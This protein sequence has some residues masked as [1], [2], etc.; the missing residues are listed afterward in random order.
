MGRILI[1]S[2]RYPYPMRSGFDLRI[3]GLHEW[4][5][6]EHEVHYLVAE[7]TSAPTRALDP[8]ASLTSIEF[9]CTGA[10]GRGASALA[11]RLYRRIAKPSFN[12][13]AYSPRLL[14]RRLV[15]L[16]AERQFDAVLI[17]TPM[18][19]VALAAVTGP[20]KIIDAVDLWY[21]RYQS[22]AQAGQ[23]H[24]LHHMRRPQ[25]ELAEYGR[26]AD[27]TLATSLHDE[28]VMRQSGLDATEVMHVPVAFEPTPLDVSCPEP[29]I[30]FAGASGLTNVDAIEYFVGD[31]LPHICEQIPEAKLLLLRADDEV[32][33][34]FG[35]IANVEILPDL[36]DVRDAY[37]RARV[38]VVPLRLG[39]G[40]KIKVLESFAFGMPTIV[41]PVAGQGIELGRYA[42]RN[43]SLEPTV[44]A[45]EVLDAMQSVEYR[46]ELVA[47]ALKTIDETYRPG[48]AYAPLMARL[49]REV[50]AR[51]NRSAAS[52]PYSS[53]SGVAV[54]SRG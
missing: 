47:S 40:I 3:A 2:P 25:V 51:A 26:L 28:R 6:R 34:R 27:L 50:A 12:S 14:E 10:E 53:A 31:V 24:L 46:D 37:R 54:S 49:E 16:H 36:E 32:R 41:S 30:L 42:Q 22:F 35:G 1:V 48:I 15:E 45:R 13:W 33:Q 20:F 17:Q 11:R 52:A 5:A 21:E 9:V 18:L 23:G 39:S 38:V 44:M 19:A 43:V 7:P 29:N 4:I 8:H